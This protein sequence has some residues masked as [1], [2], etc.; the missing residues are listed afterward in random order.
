MVVTNFTRSGRKEDRKGVDRFEK[1]SDIM[2]SAD[3]GTADHIFLF[4]EI[5]RSG[6]PIMRDITSASVV[7]EGVAPGEDPSRTV[8]W[9]LLG[10]PTSTVYVPLKVF[11]SDHIP[12]YMKKSRESDNAAICD[13]ALALKEALGFEYGCESDCREVE[14]YVDRHFSNEMSVRRY[15]RFTRRIYRRYHK[16]CA[17]K[18][19]KMVHK[20]ADYEKN[21]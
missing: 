13:A 17:G 12:D 2:T 9:T 16:I 10:S 18:S 6:K 14:K 15:D 11:G 4:N 19:P 20:I 8:M 7:F 5:S 21:D 1:A 3:V